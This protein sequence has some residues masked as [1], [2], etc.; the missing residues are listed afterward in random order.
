MVYSIKIISYI[1]LAFLSQ[2]SFNKEIIYDIPKFFEIINTV[3]IS[4]ADS[5]N[6]IKNL[7]KILE[8]YVYLDI[9]KNPPQPL[10][11]YHTP[12]DLIKEL[13]NINTY[14]RPLYEFYRDIQLLICKCQDLHLSITYI[15]TLISKISLQNSVFISPYLLNIQNEEVYA[16]PFNELHFDSNLINQIEENQDSPILRIG[17]ENPIDY[18]QKY[19]DGFMKY[20]SPQAQFVSNQRFLPMSP[21][22]LFPF[23]EEYLT[24]IKIEYKNGNKIE[25]INYKVLHNHGDDPNETEE[26][27]RKYFILS[28]NHNDNIFN[29]LQIIKPKEFSFKNKKLNFK[30]DEEDEEELKWD[31][32]YD[33]EQFK[34]R[35]DIVNEVNVIY[36]STFETKDILGAFDFFDN[37]FE[38]FYKNKYPIIVIEQFNLGGLVLLADYLKAYLDLRQLPIDYMSFRYNDDVKKNIANFY[39]MKDIRT[40]QITTASDSFKY[41]YVTDNYGVDQFGGKVIHKRTKIF[42][43]C[44]LDDSL[45]KE[46]KLN[47]KKNNNIRKPHEIIIFTDGLSY[48]S[49]SIFIKGMQ[50]NGGAIVVGYAGNPNQNNFDSSQSASPV[51]QGTNGKDDLSKEITNLGFQFNYPIMEMFSKLDYEKEENIPLEYQINPIDERVK[52]YNSYDD[53]VYQIFINQALNIFS[54]YKEKCNPEN[55]NLLLISENCI[56]SDPKMHGGY[57][58]NDEGVWSN[59]CVPSYCDEGYLFDKNK[60]QCIEIICEKEEDSKNNKTFLILTIVFSSLFFVILIIFI[61][62]S[63]IGGFDRKVYLCIPII[64][65]FILSVIF[66]ILYLI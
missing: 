21:I 59:N 14:K 7:K 8:R 49:T 23:N 5:K 53:S 46:F 37:C 64:I 35:V 17:G 44:L 36:Q 55:K 28:K 15:K 60:K 32:I 42:D 13:D 38:L 1:I 20:K 30:L 61:I 34:C 11:D 47:A 63:V 57:E 58:C 31:F 43:E 10:E 3:E 19:N 6:L 2:I 39:T 22:I 40:C 29:N 27:L 25:N 65:F 51:F 41:K 45:F 9:L 54:Y 50:L 16:I 66:L 56:F 62:C 24:N 48:S 26:F 4:E 18:I 33:N 52:I 12:V